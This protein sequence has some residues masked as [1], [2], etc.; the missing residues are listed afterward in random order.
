MSPKAK[1]APQSG[2]AHAANKGEFKN[3]VTRLLDSR[4]VDYTM[5]TYAP[6]I[7]SATGSAVDVAHAIGLPPARVFK[8][9]VVLAD[10]PGSKPMLVVIPGPDT[11]DL[12]A[13]ARAAG[14]KK[15][16]MATHQQAEQLTGLQTG[17]ISPLALTHKP[18]RVYIDARA[19]A[20]ATIAVSAGQRGVNVELPPAALI[21]ITRATT[22]ALHTE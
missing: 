22:I 10:E 8:T 11:L 9:L 3:N 21:D 19:T 6:D 5:H 4:K 13:L 7:G 15:V 12:K 17:G 2:P 14:Q 1:T 16:K 20:F 18:L